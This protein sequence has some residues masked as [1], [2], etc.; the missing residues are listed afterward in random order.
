MKRNRSS[1]LLLAACLALQTVDHVRAQAPAPRVWTDV[2][3]RPL[4]ATLL[5]ATA[6]HVRVRTVDGGE[7]TIP[8]DRLSP[9]D[10]AFARAAAAAPRPLAPRAWPETVSVPTSAVEITIAEEDEAAKRFVYHSADFEFISQDKLA[11]T[12]MKEIART[13]EATRTL[14]ME[15]PWSLSCLPPD[16]AKRFKAELYETQEAY[17]KAG[18]MPNSAGMYTSGRQV[19]MIPF[20]SLGLRKR[21]RT[22]YKDPDY[23]NDTL[24]HEVTHQL[25][26]DV[27]PFLPMW[28]IEGTAEYTESLP[29]RYGTFRV[30]AHQTG[31]REQV[32]RM[33][34]AGVPIRIESLNGL[35]RMTQNTWQSQASRSHQDMAELYVG[36]FL[37]VY[38]FNHLDGDGTGRRFQAF[39]AA[40]RG[41]ADKRR[42]FLADPQVTRLPDGRL[43][44]PSTLAS[45]DLDPSTAPFRHLHLLEDGR[46][47]ADLAAEI[48]EAY[49]KAGVP[50][51]IGE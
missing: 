17:M 8:L 1:L 51:R 2:Q 32:D 31:M 28:A 49:R 5:E 11:G 44:Y 6:E 40:V 22:W 30:R 19:F 9:A 37:L 15:L 7:F 45:P 25:M 10:Q 18:G 3:G 38:Y 46:S 21:A 14:L 43:R 4:T 20:P 42:A 39:M 35:L 41:D 26:D 24:I 50:L 47:P 36:S 16:G 23:T 48:R 27:L 33:R 34:K 29:Y 13:F 12:V